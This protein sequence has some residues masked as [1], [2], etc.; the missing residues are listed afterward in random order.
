MLVLVVFVVLLGVPKFLLYFY[1]IFIYIVT[2]QLVRLFVFDGCKNISNYTF[3]IKY[4][5]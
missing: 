4:V 5:H 3:S 1:I 2:L